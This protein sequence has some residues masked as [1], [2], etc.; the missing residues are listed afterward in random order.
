MKIAKKASS[1]S[2]TKLTIVL[3]LLLII[4]NTNSQAI[5]EV[6]TDEAIN[7]TPPGED[8]K[9]TD[10]E[11]VTKEE[12]DEA[13]DDE[14]ETMNKDEIKL[15]TEDQM[16]L[17]DLAE[18]FNPM[19]E[20]SEASDTLQDYEDMIEDEKK[21]A[22]KENGLFN[23]QSNS[24]EQHLL[25][26]KKV[27]DDLKVIET[28]KIECLKNIPEEAWVL[29]ELVICVGRGYNKIKSDID[30][31]RRKLLARAETRVRRVMAEECYS[32]AG[33]DLTHSRACDL[34][35]KDAL[36]LLWDE[37][38]YPSLLKY[39]KEKYTFTYAKLDPNQFEKYIGFF[40]ELYRRDNEILD[41]ISSHGQ[42]AMINIKK[43]IDE[44]TEKYSEK[45][46]ENGYD[47]SL[48]M[49]HEGLDQIAH[50]HSH[51]HSVGKYDP[52]FNH[53]NEDNRFHD[54]HGDHHV[55]VEA[56]EEGGIGG[57]HHENHEHNEPE[58]TALV[59]HFG[60]YRANDEP[61]GLSVDEV[62][63]KYHV[64]ENS[65]ESEDS[66]EYEQRIKDLANFKEPEET[67]DV[68]DVQNAPGLKYRKRYLKKP[69]ITRGKI[70]QNI[71]TKRIY[72]MKRSPF[73]HKP[74]RQLPIR[75]N[76]MNNKRRVTKNSIELKRI[77]EKLKRRMHSRNLKETEPK[78]KVDTKKSITDLLKQYSYKL[79]KLNRGSIGHLLKV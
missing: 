39:H 36:E 57:E 31:E 56:G 32:E 68:E 24:E 12:V 33:L 44:M 10:I 16:A 37:Y 72:H 3:A 9:L 40:A 51:Y 22:M 8:P 29:R 45:A 28:K 26:F 25:N 5:K 76:V 58:H 18:G 21:D 20:S 74:N 17:Q 15:S 23:L 73:Y 4:W 34:I 35:E 52:S 64:K 38:N 71:R 41:E 49:T 47:F 46:R 11:P 6:I 59:S 78:V 55:E 42:I 75:K 2:K 77:H 61:P 70:R 1:K 13:L 27:T 19:A 65:I 66:E 54:Y 7:N 50:H 30:Y 69:L 60:G 63:D 62:L 79:Q 67:T 14:L 48:D 53:P 43:F